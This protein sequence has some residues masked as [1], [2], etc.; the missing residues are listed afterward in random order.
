MGPGIE[1][2][3]FASGR[4]APRPRVW[5]EKNPAFPK[6]P[7]FSVPVPLEVGDRVLS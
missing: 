3:P 7:G 5:A 1:I 6:M 2:R 4:D